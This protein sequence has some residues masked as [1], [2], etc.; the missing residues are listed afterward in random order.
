[1]NDCKPIST[2]VEC[3]VKLTK[4][5]EGESLYPTIFKSLVG[6]L[7]YLTYTRPD[8]LYAVGLVNRYMENPTTTHL[9]TAKRLLRY[10]KGD[11]NDRKS[12]TG[13]VFFMEDTA[14]T[15]MS[16]KQPIVTLSTWEVEYVAAT[17]CV[18]HAI[19]L[20][21]LLKELSMPQEEPTEIYVN[22]KSAIALAKNPVF[23]DKSKHVDTRYHYL[24]EC[25]ARKDVQVE[26]MKSQ[27]QVAS[28]FTKP[29]KQ[30]DFVAADGG[31]GCKAVVGRHR[32]VDYPPYGRDFVN[33][34]PTGRFCNGKLA[35]DI[36]VTNREGGK[37]WNV[38]ER[39][40]EK[41]LHLRAQ[42]E[43]SVLPIFHHNHIL[44]SSNEMPGE[45]I[46][47]AVKLRSRFVRLSKK[48]LLY[49][50]TTYEEVQTSLKHDLDVFG[51]KVN[52]G[53]KKGAGP[54]GGPKGR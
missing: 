6:S 24:R 43:S 14:F 40:G 39:K 7:R 35:T 27:D 28:I 33:H 49:K 19:W 25:I 3:G 17:S 47:T 4:Y 1:M 12:T 13:F 54:K 38:R 15:W 51:L 37:V 41:G 18:C 11:S 31:F 2:L 32:K 23:H 20:R 46:F 22:N 16:K 8:I 29:L 34:Q 9:K 52:F 45:G 5:D 48:V 42:L 50:I 10:L 44:N 36:S 21:N 30:E 53:L 26:Y